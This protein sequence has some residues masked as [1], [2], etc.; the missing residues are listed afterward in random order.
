MSNLKDVIEYI[1]HDIGEIKD[2]QSSSLSI[3]QA[4]GLFPSYK[5]FFQHVVEQNQW[6]EDPLVTKSQ[7]PTSEIEELKKK[8]EELERTISEIKQSIQK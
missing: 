6:A 1:G 8:V 5:N 2:K 4:Y 7:L 3:S